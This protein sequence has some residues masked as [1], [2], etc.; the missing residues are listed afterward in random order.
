MSCRVATVSS[1]VLSLDHPCLC[2]SRYYYTRQSEAV[3]H[4]PVLQTRLLREVQLSLEV[5]EQL[6][7]EGIRVEQASLGPR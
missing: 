1:I 7:A 2:C 5:A 3:L 4:Y 6:Q